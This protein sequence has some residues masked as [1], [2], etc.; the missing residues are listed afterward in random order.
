MDNNDELQALI[1]LLRKENDALRLEK[2][3]LRQERD[4]LSRLNE[5]NCLLQDNSPDDIFL[6]DAK[7]NILLCT[8]SV[9]RVM[10]RDVQGEHFPAIVNEAFGADF[11]G[12]V[13][14][15]LSDVLKLGETRE[16][17]AHT[18]GRRDESGSL[19]ELYYS[20]RLSPTL[21]KNGRITG[22]VVL[23]HDITEVQNANAR[24][25]SATLAK[26][27]FLANMSHEIRTPLNAIIGMTQI[28]M[29]SSDYQKTQYCLQKIN[30]ASK[31]LL[32]LVSD[33]LDISKIESGRLELKSTGFDIRAMLGSL[34]SIHT[35]EAEDKLIDVNMEISDDFPL[36]VIG[37]EV[38]LSQII[39]NL[40][41]NAIKFTPKGGNVLLSCRASDAGEDKIR[42]E[43][44]VTDSGPGVNAN[45]MHRLYEPFEQADD[46][47]TR[48]HGGSGLGLAISKR[49]VNLMDGEI[50][51]QN[52]PEGGARFYFH[53]LIGKVLDMD[54]LFSG[55]ASG[56]PDGALD[57]SDYT[58]LIAED[59][60]INKEIAVAMLEDTR[61]AVE[62]VSN[63][64]EAVEA[65]AEDPDKYDLI[66]MDMQMPVMDGLEATRRIRA[67]N[68]PKA[69]TIPIVAMTAN[70]FA[71]DI[72]ECK[73]AGM[74]DHIG[75][76]LDMAVFLSKLGMYL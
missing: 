21:D 70:A 17:K 47:I 71:E 68:L 34:L 9:N 14:A 37:D 6:L 22:A 58:I 55:P 32:R 12:T 63:G 8:A 57:F 5:Y 72:E 4:S 13:A 19:N 60:E 2:A 64:Q 29:T 15:A 50:S 20:L 16:V 59:L 73:K 41:S 76:P 43:M 24:A 39:T 65:F 26:S 54:L 33:V 40:L 28:G 53:V 30:S 74:T 31:Q 61:A 52:M 62:C 56:A 45:H 7:L 66:L 3:S 23:A 44:A 27:N 11:E 25:Y 51:V 49:I 35:I 42:L 36:Y 1:S 46:S 75:K 69:V 67:F 18:V 10:G 48:K 38:R